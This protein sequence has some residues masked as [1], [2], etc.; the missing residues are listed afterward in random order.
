MNT[1]KIKAVPNEGQR[2][3][4][5]LAAKGAGIQYRWSS[6]EG[7]VV[8]ETQ[9]TWNPLADFGDAMELAQ[10]LLMTFELRSDYAR[11]CVGETC[12]E[13]RDHDPFA[14]LRIAVVKVAVEIGKNCS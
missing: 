9:R 2:R 7:F 5:E 3:W 11:A 8:V 1:E 14:A 13:E 10:K 4:L 6:K 12:C